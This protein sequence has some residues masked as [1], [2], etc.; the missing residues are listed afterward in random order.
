[1]QYKITCNREQLYE[2]TKALTFTLNIQ[3][4]NLIIDSFPSPVKEKMLEKSDEVNAQLEVL[5]KMV[6]VKTELN[7]ALGTPSLLIKMLN[8]LRDL[9]NNY[10]NTCDFVLEEDETHMLAESIEFYCRFICAQLDINIFPKNVA[11]KMFLCNEEGDVEDILRNIRKIVWNTNHGFGVG[12]NYVS[13]LAYEMYSVMRHH[14][15]ENPGVKWS[16]DDYMP[17]S[18]TKIP[19]IEVEKIK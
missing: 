3:L 1:M 4:G 19:F 18:V 14:M 12:Y 6:W 5:K 2:M 7:D 11:S 9:D 15:R 16:V 17:L 13:D 10:T 8:F